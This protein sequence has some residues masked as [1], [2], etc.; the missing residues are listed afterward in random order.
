MNQYQT[1]LS[2]EYN[3]WGVRLLTSDHDMAKLYII[4]SLSLSLEFRQPP[5]S[6]V[7]LRKGIMAK[8]V[9]TLAGAFATVATAVA[10]GVTFG[11]VESLNNAVKSCAEYTG[12]SFME[13]SVR[14]G[15]EAVGKGIATAGAAVAAGVTF[16]Q[17]D[18]LNDAVVSCAKSTAES[19]VAAAK[20]TK[21][22]INESLDGIPVVGH[23]KGAIHYATGDDS[24]G[25]KAMKAASRSAGVVAG[26]TAGFIVGGPVGAVVGGIAYGAAMD[27]IITGA[28]SAVH[29]EW[30]PHGQ[31]AAWEAVANGK[32]DQEVIDGVVGGVV[33]PAFDALGGYAAGKYVKPKPTNPSRSPPHFPVMPPKPSQVLNA[34][35]KPPPK[36]PVTRQSANN[37]I[38]EKNPSATG[39]KIISTA[40]TRASTAMD[41]LK[42][43]SGEQNLK[44][45]FGVDAEP[46]PRN[47]NNTAM[48]SLKTGSDEQNL[49]AFGA[50]AKPIPQNPNNILNEEQMEPHSQQPKLQPPAKPTVHAAGTSS[51]QRTRPS[52]A[53]KSEAKKAERLKKASATGKRS[54][55]RGTGRDRGGSRGGGQGGRGGGEGGRGGGQGGR[56]GGQGGRSGGPGNGKGN[57]RRGLSMTYPEGFYTNFGMS[58]ELFATF[59]DQGDGTFIAAQGFIFVHAVLT[60]YD[61]PTTMATNNE[62]QQP[63]Q[64]SSAGGLW[65]TCT[66]S[67]I[68]SSPC[69]VENCTNPHH[70]CSADSPLNAGATAHVYLTSQSPEHHIEYMLLIP[71]CSGCNN[72]WQC[73][74]NDTNFPLPDQVAKPLRARPGTQAMFIRIDNNTAR[75][76][77]DGK[78]GTGQGGSFEDPFS[79]GGGNGSSSA[80]S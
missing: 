69:C 32:D 8:E 62:T 58:E 36:P 40:S 59:E 34:G 3:R 80:G 28:D 16:G 2:I 74:N 25:D 64:A 78:R 29:E 65:A 15:G 5:P 52:S 17:V 31:I 22:T 76:K 61:N 60:S 10:A 35:K 19:T 33:T 4:I 12:K 68:S 63:V 21:N 9:S 43:G 1:Y 73:S 48:D 38:N 67:P 39:N 24:A 71:T 20:A 66:G 47:P 27:G 75:R 11:Q 44:E 13:T 41:S 70:G 14:H 37:I 46:I 6:K 79:H 23:L 53:K 51:G 30:R 45:E 57:R 55:Q 7:L 18:A 49:K 26:G 50:D 56:G 77:G 54:G 72:H 42:T